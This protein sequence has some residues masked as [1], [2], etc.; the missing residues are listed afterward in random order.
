MVEDATRRR[1]IVLAHRGGGGLAPENTLAAFDNGLSLGSD[2]I[3]LDVHLARDGVAVVIHDRTLDRTTDGSGAVADVDASGLDVFDAGYRFTRNGGYPW[4]GRGCRIPRLRDVLAR[5][6]CPVLIE[7]KTPDPRLAA[8]VADDVRVAGADSRV[9]IGSFHAP[10]LEAVRACAPHLRRGADR[11]AIRANSRPWHGPLPTADFHSFQV[12]EVFGDERI[13]TPE[14][15]QRAH[16]RGVDV[17]VWTVD[18]EDEI[19]RLLD[20]GVDGLITDR[21]DVAVPVV[22][23]W[24]QSFR[25]EL[26]TT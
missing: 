9:L 19:R 4:R 20:W 13:V 5:L 25:Q 21:P 15:V 26:M 22:H 1:P 11:E 12:P 17:I 16:A 14:F 23:G 24:W 7:L 2:G 18:R 10:A 8:A 3:E 6:A